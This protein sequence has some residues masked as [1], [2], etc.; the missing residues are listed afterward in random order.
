MFVI[1]NKFIF[2]KSQEKLKFSNMKLS[3]RKLCNQ[4]TKLDTGNIE[5][6]ILKKNYLTYHFDI[7]KF[8]NAVKI[9][10]I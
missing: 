6:Y 5:Y 9:E 8:G 2:E 10:Q 7:G 4:I 1:C 3:S